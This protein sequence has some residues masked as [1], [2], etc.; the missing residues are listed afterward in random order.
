MAHL[1]PVSVLA[2]HIETF[3]GKVWQNQKNAN[4]LDSIFKDGEV[5]LNLAPATIHC[6]DKRGLNH[7]EIISL[8]QCVGKTVHKLPIA[9][10]DFMNALQ[11]RYQFAFD[12]GEDRFKNKCKSIAYDF[13]GD[14]PMGCMALF[15]ATEMY[16]VN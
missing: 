1:S 11:E 12:F 14:T 8:A 9:D 15:T 4:L 7:L 3:K 6:L 16:Q 2:Q 10:V 13:R 5:C